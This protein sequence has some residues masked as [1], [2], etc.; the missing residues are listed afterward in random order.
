MA[1]RAKIVNNLGR[2]FARF[3]VALVLGQLK[4]SYYR[5]VLVFTFVG[6]KYMLA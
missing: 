2:W 1:F 6:R 4:I 3:W 5:P